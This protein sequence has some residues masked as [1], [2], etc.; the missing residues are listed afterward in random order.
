MAKYIAPILKKQKS[1]SIIN[2]ASTLG[3]TAIPNTIIYSSSKGAI[4]Q[5]TRN[6]ALDL[7]S[8]NIRVNSISPGRIDTL[9]REDQ[10][11]MMGLTQ[12]QLNNICTEASCL[13]R[14]G[15]AQ[16]IANAIIFLASDLC[17]FMTGANLVIDGGSSI[18]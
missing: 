14:I 3:L 4:I 12:E 16:E 2:I 11:K 1:G 13:K 7:G 17:P 5:M 18:I 8:S 9:L 10:T 15:Q 6:L